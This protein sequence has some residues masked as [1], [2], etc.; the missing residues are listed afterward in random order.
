MHNPYFPFHALGYQGNPFRAVTDAEWVELAILPE[1]IEAVLKADE[2]YIQILGDKGH[3]KTTT[4]LA[5]AARFYQD[6]WRTAYEHLEVGADH[7]TTD[8]VGLELDVFLLDETQRL[9]R[10]E[11]HRLLTSGLGHLV[12]AGHEDLTPLFAYF[13]LTLITVRFDT[14]P[15]FHVASV[16]ARRLDY[17]ALPGAVERVTI[18]PEAIAYLHTTFGADLRRTEQVLYEVFES[19]RGREGV[20]VVGVEAVKF[21]MRNS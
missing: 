13:G 12:V 21:V 7:F 5:L 2:P 16:I 20:R 14:A 19:L 1:S 4:L 18:S 15:L 11:R 17:F 3:G 6:G 9:T 10:G 8:L